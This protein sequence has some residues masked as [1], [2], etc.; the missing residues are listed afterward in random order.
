MLDTGRVILNTGPTQYPV[1]EPN[2]VPEQ[3]IGDELIFKR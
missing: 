3:W 1:L 2:I